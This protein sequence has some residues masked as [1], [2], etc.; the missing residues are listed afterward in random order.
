[1][2]RLDGITIV[3]FDVEG[4]LVTT[5]FSYSIWYEAIPQKYAQKYGLDVAIAKQIIEEEYSKVGDQ[6]LEWYDVR[7]WFSKFGL[8]SPE[9]V[10]E[11]YRHRVSCYPEVKEVLTELSK[12]YT[13]IAASG[14][15][16][17]FLCHLLADIAP[18]FGRVFSSLSDY[19]QLK[20]PEFY[21]EICRVMGVRPEEIVH[22]GD[23]REFDFINP[24]QVGIHAFHLDRSGEQSGSLTSLV[25]LTA[26]LLG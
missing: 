16:R 19:R 18:Y 6:R 10:L 13:L 8:G 2:S 25:D 5:D 15:M 14:S 7:Y 4:T 1:M 26:K 20:T 17:E 23:N 21:R 24:R 11:S 9:T 3:S 12:R 22:V